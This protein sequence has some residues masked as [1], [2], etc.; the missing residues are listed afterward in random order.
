MNED[1][2]EKKNRYFDFK[3]FEFRFKEKEKKERK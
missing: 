2:V 1:I 3:I